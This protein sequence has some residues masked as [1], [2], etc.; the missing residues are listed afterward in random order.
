[1]A[2]LQVGT[3]Q[4]FTVIQNG[5]NAAASGDHVK[6]MPGGVGNVYGESLGLTSKRI[7]LSGCG[8]DPTT[9]LPLIK[10][11][12]PNTVGALVV[13]GTGGIFVENLSFEVTG[14]PAA[15]TVELNVA[16]DWISR[17]VADGNGSGACLQ[18]QFMDN[19]LLKNGT[20]AMRGSCL[21]QIIAHNMTAV[22]QSIAGLYG[23]GS[24]DEFV[25]CLTANCNNAGLFGANIG[26]CQ[27]CIGD[28]TTVLMTIGGTLMDLTS[29]GFANYAGGDF[30]LAE[31]SLAFVPGLGMTPMTLDGRRRAAETQPSQPRA[32]AGCYAPF[33]FSPLFLSGSSQVRR[34]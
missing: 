34:F 27:D 23:N 16:Q 30:R 29:I 3:N 19:C 14:I 2:L 21:G 11:K 24:S 17:C 20:Y 7:R 33:P 28:D 10:V 26:Y 8:V 5:I 18:A 25:Q 15:F 32:Y 31:T 4:P 9:G 13:S 1:M 12:S 22:N 6:V